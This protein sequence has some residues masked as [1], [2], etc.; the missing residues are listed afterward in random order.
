MP[1]LIRKATQVWSVRRIEGSDVVQREMA[2]IKFIEASVPG[3]LVSAARR[4]PATGG[5][6]AGSWAK[7]G[8]A[9]TMVARTRSSLATPMMRERTDKIA[10]PLYSRSSSVLPSGKTVIS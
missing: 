7:A 6:A 2:L 3:E 10:N 1:V 8:P 9:A 5:A 4:G